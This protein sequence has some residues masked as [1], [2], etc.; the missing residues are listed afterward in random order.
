MENML[1]KM[2]DDYT[3][4]LVLDSGHWIVEENPGKCKTT[5][6]P[7]PSRRVLIRGVDRF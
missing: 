2:N 4:D 6:T 1:S 7:H 3:T 5:P